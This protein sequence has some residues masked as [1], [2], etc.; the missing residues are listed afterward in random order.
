MNV[1]RSARKHGI[2]SNDAIEAATWPLVS[3]PLDDEDPR[4]FL[5]LGFDTHGRLLE[6]VV[7]V[8]DDGSEELIHAM[9]CRPKYLGMLG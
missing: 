1:R 8:W 4:R 9:K 5:R 7:L 3:V 6:L 2:S